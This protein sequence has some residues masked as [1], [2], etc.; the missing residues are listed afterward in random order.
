MGA[1]FT[2]SIFQEPII[3]F[4]VKSMGET[5]LTAILC[6]GDNK[7]T[8]R[9]LWILLSVTLYVTMAEE[10]KSTKPHKSKTKAIIVSIKP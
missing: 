3:P 4:L 8:S 1:I 7:E 5:K 2:Q 9:M 6:M 10:T